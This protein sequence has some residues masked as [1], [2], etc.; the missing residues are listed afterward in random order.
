MRCEG[1]LASE[2]GGGLA[3]EDG[4]W[5]S[6]VWALEGG[7][8]PGRGEQGRESGQLQ[9]RVVLG[10]RTQRL[11]L[12]NRFWPN[13]LGEGGGAYCSE[14]CVSL[15]APK[16]KKKKPKESRRCRPGTPQ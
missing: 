10:G 3:K 1:G 11:S 8:F 16:T 6:R 12:L 2:E 9:G 14:E 5:G 7:W 4:F 15:H 13:C